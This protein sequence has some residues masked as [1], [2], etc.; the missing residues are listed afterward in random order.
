MVAEA[1]G[2]LETHGIG[3]VVTLFVE[4]QRKDERRKKQ[5]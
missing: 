5:K 3:V 4:E 1:V 2:F